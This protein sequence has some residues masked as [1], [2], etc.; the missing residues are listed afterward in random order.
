MEV[1]KVIERHGYRLQDI[2]KKMKM[3]PSTLEGTIGGNPTVG[4][5]RKVAEAVGC[6]V[7]EFFF[8][9]LPTDYQLPAIEPAASQ[10]SAEQGGAKDLPFGDQGQKQGE[11]KSEIPTTLV[12]LVRCT[13]CGQAIRLFA[14]TT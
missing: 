10:P 2:S 3:K 9:E 11:Q 4:T 7:A 5:L 6:P 12:G 13:K 8:D 1:I 14:E